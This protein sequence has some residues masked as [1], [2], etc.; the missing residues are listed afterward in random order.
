MKLMTWMT[1]RHLLGAAVFLTAT[2][3]VPASRQ[4]QFIRVGVPTPQTGNGGTVPI[5]GTSRGLTDRQGQKSLLPSSRGR[6]KDSPT[7]SIGIKVDKYTREHEHSYSE[8]A[9]SA[10]TTAPNPKTTAP[11]QVPKKQDRSQTG[12]VTVE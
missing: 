6:G 8:P 10:T 5:S 1:F 11:V 2:A 12:D 3:A 7:G 9:D 4:G